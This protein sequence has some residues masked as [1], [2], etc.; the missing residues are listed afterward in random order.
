MA[1]FLKSLSAPRA[2]CKRRSRL[3]LNATAMGSVSARRAWSR[4]AAG[5]A[6]SPCSLRLALPSWRE[7]G[8]AC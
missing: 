6:R 2:A 1:L 4:D 3:G 5:Q 8:D 7:P